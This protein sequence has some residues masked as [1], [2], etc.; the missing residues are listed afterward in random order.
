MRGHWAIWPDLPTSIDF[1]GVIEDTYGEFFYPFLAC[2]D[3]LMNTN[4]SIE[5]SMT[6]TTLVFSLFILLVVF[7]SQN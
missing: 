2:P 7:L 5:S 4:L 1:E 6:S 3:P